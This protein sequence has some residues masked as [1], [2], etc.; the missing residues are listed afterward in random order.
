MPLQLSLQ[1]TNLIK[2]NQYDSVLTIPVAVSI[3]FRDKTQHH[4]FFP[5]TDTETWSI[6]RYPDP[7]DIFL[8]IF[9]TKL[10]EV[11]KKIKDK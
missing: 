7:F 9:S 10:L 4:S 2:S 11:L 3:M 6:S 1:E 5:D 8:S